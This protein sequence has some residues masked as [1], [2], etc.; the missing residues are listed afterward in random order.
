[1]KPRHGWPAWVALGLVL[2]TVEAS[3]RGASAHEGDTVSLAVQ[4][5]PDMPAGA[6]RRILAIEIGD[7]LL[8]DGDAVGS[9]RL[10]IRCAGDVA[11]VE[12]A[13]EAGG[14]PVDRTFRMDGFPED[15][16]PRALA[17]IGLE[18]LAARS[19]AVRARIEAQQAPS[20]APKVPELAPQSPPQRRTSSLRLGVAGTWRRF[21]LGPGLQTWGGQAQLGWVSGPWLWSA[22]LDAGGTSRDVELGR[23]RALLLSA[24]TAFGLTESTRHAAFAFTLGGRLGVA[25]LAGT[26]AAPEVIT[27]TT[28]RPWGGPMASLGLMGVLRRWTVG[29]TVEAGRSIFTVEGT[30]EGTTVLA[31]GGTWMA[32][33][34][35]AAVT[36]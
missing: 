25:R 21:W 13:G 18:L 32:L 11:W 27:G 31:V 20:A 6:L 4:A 5:C 35:G 16:T 9:H 28:V 33:S 34:L 14:S 8:P 26:A 2:T 7:L 10:T 3:A 17:L 36:P 30:A 15:A 22:D 12:A 24:S 23:T 29:L 1:V 19:P